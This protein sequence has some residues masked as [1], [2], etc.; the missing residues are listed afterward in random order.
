M[1]THRTKSYSRQGIC[2][3]AGPTFVGLISRISGFQGNNRENVRSFLSY[4]VE[5]AQIEGYNRGI[6]IALHFVLSW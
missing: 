2:H 6:K 4:D 1:I 3:L 5:N